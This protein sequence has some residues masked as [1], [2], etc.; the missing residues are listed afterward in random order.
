MEYLHVRRAI[1]TSFRRINHYTVDCILIQI[2][3]SHR[4]VV[5]LMH[6]YH[7]TLSPLRQV[8]LRHTFLDHEYLLP[9]P[10]MATT[11]LQ[12][13]EVVSSVAL[14]TTLISCSLTACC[15]CNQMA[16]DD[17]VDGGNPAPL[18]MDKLPTSTGAGWNHHQQLQMPM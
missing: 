15:W 14:K 18:G 16:E 8:F 12:G 13:S 3:L 9:G 4:F 11:G 17:S 7:T 10:G 2:H 6:F 1:S 5:G